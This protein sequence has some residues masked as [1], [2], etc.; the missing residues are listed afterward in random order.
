[1]SKAVFVTDNSEKCCDCI[2]SNPDGDYCPF[3]GYISMEEY[4]IKKPD[5]CPLKPMP[6]KKPEYLSINSEK[7]YCDGWNACI[8]EICGEE[9]EDDN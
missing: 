9:T 5:D 7:G 6:E 3:H 4:S 1:M 8:D 2:F